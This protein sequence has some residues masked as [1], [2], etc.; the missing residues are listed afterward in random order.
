MESA[1]RVRR[2][3]APLGAAPAI[4]PT[5]PTA[6]PR[7]VAGGARRSPSSGEPRRGRAGRAA[8]LA[9]GG[10]G[11]RQSRR[12]AAGRPLAVQADALEHERTPLN[13]RGGKRRQRRIMTAKQNNQKPRPSAP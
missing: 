12:A 10:G 7:A 6:G 11:P 1:V 8:A 4:L 9:G 5:G 3:I 2:A 13:A